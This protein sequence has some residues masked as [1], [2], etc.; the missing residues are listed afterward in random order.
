[1]SATRFYF[2]QDDEVITFRRDERGR[3][4]GL[5]LQNRAVELARLK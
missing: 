2:T 5:A 1:M 4:V 3:V